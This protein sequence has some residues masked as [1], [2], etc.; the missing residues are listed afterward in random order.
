MIDITKQNLSDVQLTAVEY[1]DGPLLV[2]A[3]AGA[4]KTRVLTYKI[5]H[6]L[7]SGVPAWNILALTFTNKA[8]KEMKERIEK[9]V[10]NDSIRGLRMGTF[11]SMFLRILRDEVDFTDYQRDFSIYDSSDAKSLIKS[12]IKEIGLD[13]KVYKASTVVGRISDAKNALLLPEAYENNMILRQRDKNAG[14]DRVHEIYSIYRK[15]CIAANAMDFDDLLLNTY[16]L[17]DS[18]PAICEKYSCRFEHILVDEYQDTNFA[19]HQIIAQLTHP[20]SKICV[21]GDD[22]QSI[23]AFRGAEIDNILQFAKQYPNAK[24]VKLEQNYRS[25]QTIVNAANSIIQHNKWQIPKVVFSEKEVGEKIHILSAYSDKE[26]SI[27]V[28]GKIIQLKRRESLDCDQIAILYRTNAQS[29]SFEDALRNENIPYRIHGGLSFYQRKEIKDVLA[30]MRVAC[31]P[32]DEEA[33][34][35]IINYPARGIGKTTE[36]KLIQAAIVHEVSLWDVINNPDGYDVNVNKGTR[37][38]LAEFADLLQSFIQSVP[39]TSGYQL[40]GKIIKESGI[41]AEYS[42]ERSPENLSAMENL[43]ELL[44]AIQGFESDLLEEE[45]TVKVTLPEYLSQ[46]SLQTDADKGDDDVPKIT[47]MTVHAAKGLEYEAIFVTGM[48]DELFPCASSLYNPK[49]REEERRLFYVAVTRAKRF[50]I[51]TYAKN[52]FRYGKYEVS[53]PSPFLNEIDH[54]YIINE[55]SHF[56]R[57]STNENNSSSYRFN[58]INRRDVSSTP[59]GQSL[60][61]QSRLKRLTPTPTYSQNKLMNQTAD[62][63]F[64]VDD[65]VEHERFGRGIVIEIEGGGNGE[66]A[67]VKFEHAGEKNLLLKFAKMRKIQAEET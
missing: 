51:L 5:A 22:A 39:I 64:K 15:R 9:L 44:S 6:L 38:K 41:A 61:N 40:V 42:R 60:L 25:T 66:K 26:E 53:N 31:N 63:I 23:Y 58:E 37:A 52:R 11:H 1:N 67:K 28:V 47:L 18:H 10:G 4:G 21:V 62:S 46:I 36:G 45:G 13:E 54:R 59:H 33:L 34:K 27:R 30:Y 20:S 43:E 12:I 29:R 35:R 14:I 32:H 57:M 19:Q 17:F 24:V 56:S 48:E 49:E 16:L 8:A 7:N 50:C 65:W 3:G 2:V 55:D